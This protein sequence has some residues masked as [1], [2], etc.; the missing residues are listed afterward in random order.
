MDFT[1]PALIADKNR[2][3]CCI[4][5][6]DKYKLD[7][8]MTHCG[9]RFC[10]WCFQRTTWESYAEAKQKFGPNTNPK[11]HHQCF[12]QCPACRQL[13]LLYFLGNG[14]V[15]DVTKMVEWEQES[16]VIE[17]EFVNNDFDVDVRN[18]DKRD[19]CERCNKPGAGQHVDGCA[20]FFHKRCLKQWQIDTNFPIDGC[21]LCDLA[22]QCHADE[23]LGD[24][25]YGWL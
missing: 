20:C 16:V 4:C 22:K 23:D 2:F 25:Y 24:Y 15:I 8:E 14:R 12:Q 17:S 18:K 19:V 10:A 9:H 7:S 3:Y 5:L 21:P 1:Q 13:C 11:N 6:E